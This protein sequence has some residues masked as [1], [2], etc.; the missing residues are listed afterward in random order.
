MRS[1]RILAVDDD[2]HQLAAIKRCL[3]RSRFEVTTAASGKVG[4]RMAREHPPDLVLLDVSMPT[5]SGYEF[6]RRFRR[7]NGTNGARFDEIPVIFLTA[8]AAPDQ[9]TAGLNADAVDYITKPFEPD[10]LRARIRNQLRRS[11]K[12]RQ[13]LASVQAEA[14]RLKAAVGAM[15]HEA[16]A[17][18][19][20]LLELQDHLE[21][22]EYVRRPT[23]QSDLLS[24]AGKDVGR[25]TQSLLRIAEWPEKKGAGI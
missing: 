14:S 4:L 3:R 10:E 8:L 19:Q 6:L 22:A 25:L 13:A 15:A 23:L 24:R 18:G 21:L 2:A 20:P 9:K 16:R 5:M 12:Q 1:I 7:L 11:R 17:C